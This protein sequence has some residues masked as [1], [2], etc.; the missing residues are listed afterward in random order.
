MKIG[1]CVLGCGEFAKVFATSIQPLL[2]EINLY[3]ASRSPVKAQ[4]YKKLFNGAG[5]FRSYKDAV[6]NSNI[7]AV[8][9]PTPHYLH[10]EHVTLA[11]EYKKHILLEKPLATTIED[12]EQIVFLGEQAN[13]KLMVA[14]NYRFLPA[15]QL[16]K[17][18]VDQGEIGNIRV[19]QIQEES[20]NKLVDWRADVH[21]NGGGV[22]IDAG[23][24]KIH[25]L[26][27][28]LGQ[29]ETIYA[30]TPTPRQSVNEGEDTLLFTAQWAT[31]VIGLIYHSWNVAKHL[32]KHWISVSG[33]KGKIYFEVDKPELQ[34]EQKGTFRTIPLCTPQNGLL[35][36]TKEFLNSIRENRTPQIDGHEGLRD[37]Y[38]IIKAYESID[39]KLPLRIP[40]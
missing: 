38:L 18:L 9:I 32:S 10:L 15:V 39:K 28:M 21:K 2:P 36:M 33:D 13:I 24:H 40:S 17:Q 12:G 3:F 22:F 4:Y 5:Y 20:T 14:E 6:Q 26:R 25:F 31:G 11:A 19:I 1:L 23:I 30:M 35:N 7:D 16:C 8:Y 29:P 27:Y 34:I 37:L